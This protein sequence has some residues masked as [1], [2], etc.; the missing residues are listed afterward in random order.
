[1][2]EVVGR[3]IG[4]SHLRLLTNTIQKKRM[5]VRVRWHSLII[6]SPMAKAFILLLHAGFRTETGEVLPS[7]ALWSSDS[8]AADTSPK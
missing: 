2:V 5:R 6:T 7:I 8:D 1:M 4:F 3:Y